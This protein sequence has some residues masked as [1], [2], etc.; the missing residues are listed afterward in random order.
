MTEY[1]TESILK[2]LTEKFEMVNHDIEVNYVN[3][4]S[5][6]EVYAEYI[7]KLQIKGKGK[8]INRDFINITKNGIEVLEEMDVYGLLGCIDSFGNALSDFEVKADE[9][10]KKK[11]KEKKEQKKQEEAKKA[12]QEAAEQQAKEATEE[13]VDLDDKDLLDDEDLEEWNDKTLK[14][15]EEELIRLR[16]NK[17]RLGV[18]DNNSKL[19]KLVK[20]FSKSKRN[21]T[22]EKLKTYKDIKPK[23]IGKFNEF[24]EKVVIPKIKDKNE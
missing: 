1:T 19:N 4:D 9:D 21:P 20:K 14:I 7:T 24:I 23:N 2:Q 22:G 17:K 8:R 12:G 5:P 18:A 16:G 10:K 15:F 3:Q 6:Q 13:D 11:I